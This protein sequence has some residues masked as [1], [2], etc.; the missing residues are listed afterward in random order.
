MVVLVVQTLI[1]NVFMLVSR[2][3]LLVADGIFWWL[4]HSFQQKVILMYFYVVLILRLCHSSIL[5]NVFV[6]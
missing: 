3:S 4:Y 1:C 2:S 5:N 6:Y